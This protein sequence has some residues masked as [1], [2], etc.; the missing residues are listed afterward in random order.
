MTTIAFNPAR[1]RSRFSF[2]PVFDEVFNDLMSGSISGKG[3]ALLAPVNIMETE[4]GFQIQFAVPGFK[5]ED[6]KI[7]V[8]DLLLTV[9]AEVESKT[10]EENNRF[11][12]REFKRSAFKRS[13]NLPENID[14]EAMKATYTDGIL[15]LDLARKTEVQPNNA[16]TIQ[17]N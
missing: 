12:R 10:E 6:F 17:V 5:K 15:V 14:K 8:N 7:E 4:N 11:T 13:F 9:S 2:S 16:I 1:F 3:S